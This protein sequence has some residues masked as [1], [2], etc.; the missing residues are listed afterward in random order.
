M[1]PPGERAPAADAYLWDI[2]SGALGPE[3]VD[4]QPHLV[5]VSREE[6]SG[7]LKSMTSGAA[8]TLIL[9]PINPAAVRTLLEQAEEQRRAVSSDRNAILDCLFES[10][11][12]LQECDQERMNFL[13]RAVHDFRT[14]LTAV[15]GYC[16]LLLSGELGPLNASQQEVLTRTLQSTRRLTRLASALFQWSSG[17]EARLEPQT[18]SGHI[19][20]CC[21]KALHEVRPLAKEKNIC[22]ELELEAPDQPLYLDPPQIE[23]LLVS[24][25]ENSCKFTPRDGYIQVRGF[26]AFWDRRSADVSRE[27]V[28]L[29]RRQRESFEANAYRMEIADNGMGGGPEHLE[30]IFQGCRRYEGSGDRSGSGLGLAICKQIMDEH[31]GEIHAEPGSTGMT[32][33]FHLPYLARAGKPAEDENGG[34]HLVAETVGGARV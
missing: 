3:T 5:A 21:R 9:K 25:L 31:G 1:A 16:G 32:F 17:A 6:A 12:R 11:V 29:E 28:L 18:S 22:V 7:V 30:N 26:P 2:D 27:R 14:P 24:L 15:N 33:I 23:H 20:E 10:H 13:A 34:I 4:V 19:E 8:V